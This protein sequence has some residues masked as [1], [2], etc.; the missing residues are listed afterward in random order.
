MGR[1]LIGGH[2]H[3]QNMHLNH[4]I[5]FNNNH[6]RYEGFVWSIIWFLLGGKIK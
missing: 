5:I 2:F 6:S 4:A 3:V 1:L